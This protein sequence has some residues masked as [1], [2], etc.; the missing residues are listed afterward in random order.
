MVD[1]PLSPSFCRR[2]SHEDLQILICPV[3]D[4]D[5]AVLDELQADAR[6]SFS[7]LGRR[8]GLSPPA[9]TERVR[10]LE[11]V[12]IIRGYH[13]EIDRQ[14]LGVSVGA[15]VRVATSGGP[16]YPRIFDDLA[17]IPEMQSC[18][19]V[20]G[21]DCLVVELACRDMSRLE[22]LV[23]HLSRYGSTTTSVMFSTPFGHRPITRAILE[24]D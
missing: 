12:G 15:I 9:V 8:V 3:D 14:A 2:V 5:W 21:A 16:N 10:R 1:Q 19:H 24:R 22:E 6:L 4:I 18:H 20:T 17:A 7:E 11:E 13:A 23:G